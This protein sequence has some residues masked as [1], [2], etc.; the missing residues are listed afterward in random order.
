MFGLAAEDANNDGWDCPTFY[1]SLIEEGKT[2]LRG[3][4][5]TFLR[6]YRE[7]YLP[8]LPREPTTLKHIESEVGDDFITISNRYTYLCGYLATMKD[9]MDLVLSEKDTSINTGVG[10]FAESLVVIPRNYGDTWLSQKSTNRGQLGY[11]DVPK[12]RLI[13]PV[14]QERLTWSSTDVGKLTDM[15]NLNSWVPEDSRLKGTFELASLMQD[16]L[17]DVVGN[18]LN[19]YMPTDFGG[20]GKPAPFGNFQNTHTFLRVWKNGQYLDLTKVCFRQTVKFLRDAGTFG[21]QPRVPMVLEHFT[22][23]DPVFTDWV[24]GIDLSIP[25]LH[26]D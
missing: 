1:E 12:L 16:A 17:L 25:V 24:K 6:S 3:V 10:N 19:A 13:L 14:R 21:R 11:I 23:C 20:A 7:D 9:F 22:K 5:A 26:G 18:K 15:G 4:G 8:E 2:L